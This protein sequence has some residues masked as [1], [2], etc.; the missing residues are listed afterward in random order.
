MQ[1]GVTIPVQ[2]S[3]AMA[4]TIAVIGLIVI[5]YVAYR[6]W[7]FA[8][9]MRK[10]IREAVAEVLGTQEHAKNMLAVVSPEMARVAASCVSVHNE[11]PSAHG[12]FQRMNDAFIRA[13]VAENLMHHDESLAAHHAAFDR[14]PDRRELQGAV[15]RLEQ[16][17]DANTE[18][19]LTEL[20]A[21]RRGGRDE[22]AKRS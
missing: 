1:S 16:K 21:E 20:R 15:D 19:I 10:E 5:A 14:Y 2:L 3:T 13:H 6:A 7:M 9:W 11:L 4:G 17:I 22:G 12:Q 8:K 18:L